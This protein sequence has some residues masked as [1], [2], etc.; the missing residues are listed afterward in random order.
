MDKIHWGGSDGTK[1][2]SHKKLRLESNF[3]ESP[4]SS[5]AGLSENTG[6][7][8]GGA[9]YTLE[10]RSKSSGSDLRLGE[11]IIKR[12]WSMSCFSRSP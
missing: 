12:S 7:A 2:G 5:G 6:D 10:S 1:V 3:R 8:S 11:G 9:K 4:N